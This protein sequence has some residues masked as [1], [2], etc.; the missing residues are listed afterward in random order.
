MLQRWRNERLTAAAVDAMQQQSLH[1]LRVGWEG[2]AAAVRVLYA[3]L[4][5]QVLALA[6]RSGR[7]GSSGGGSS[8]CGGSGGGGGGGGGGGSP[9]HSSPRRW[10]DGDSGSGVAEA[11]D[12]HARSTAVDD[13]GA[14]G[15]ALPQLADAFAAYAASDEAKPGNRPRGAAL[16]AVMSALAAC[17]AELADRAG[18][19]ER[20]AGRARTRL[21]QI[22]AEYERA[23][24]SVALAASAEPSDEDD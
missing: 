2:Q 6:P 24:A 12:P 22:H 16:V 13:G 7:G 19:A 21:D 9:S 8:G 5:R 20:R 11:E 10:I 14:A 23:V 1:E 3:E 15:S 18:V 4:R 17:H